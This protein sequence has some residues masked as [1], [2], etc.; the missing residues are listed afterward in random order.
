MREFLPER[1]DKEQNLV[2]IK[3]LRTNKPLAP[4]ARRSDPTAKDAKRD[5]TQSREMQTEDMIAW[6]LHNGWSLA[7]IFPY[8][9]DLGLSGTLRPDQR[10]DMLRLFDDL[11]S[12]KLDGGTIACWQENRPFRDETHIYY[13]QLID[14]MLQHNVVMLVMSPRLY[15]YDMRDPFDMERLRDKFKEAA[16]FIPKHVKGWLHPAR[17]RAAWEYGEWAGLGSLPPGFIVDYDE[18]SPTY[19]KIIPYWPHIEKTKEKFQ[20]FMELGGDIG[21]FYKRLRKS[22]IIYPEFESWVDKRITNRFNLSR[23]PG[24]GYYIRGRSSLVSLLTHPLHYGY[25]PIENVIR[26]DDQGNKIREF[27]PVIDQELLDFAYYRLARTD[28]DGNPIAANSKPRR[29]FQRDSN[30]LYGLLKFRIHSNQGKARTSSHGGRAGVYLIEIM[31]QDDYICDPDIILA[32]PCG[33]IDTIIVNRMMEHVRDISK[34]CESAETFQQQVNEIR[35]KR[36]SRIKQLEASINDINRNQA[37]LTL[38]LGKVELEREEVKQIND[39]E[40]L[41][42][43]QRR[44]ELITEQIDTLE[45]ERRTL[46]QTKADV[47]KQA[48]NDYGSLDEELEELE[49]LWPEYTFEHRRNLINFV[50]KEVFID[51]ISTHWLRIQVLWLHE[52]WGREEMFY[53]RKSGKR[54]EWTDEEIELL[55]ATYASTPYAQLRALF[56]DKSWKAIYDKGRFGLGIMRPTTR[57]GRPAPGEEFVP[58]WEINLSYSD[59]EFMQEQGIN[60]NARCTNWIPVYQ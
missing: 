60:H 22:P 37:G 40:K 18:H 13:N 35:K 42:R 26:R 47:E 7:L 34:K 11:D 6:G 19:K 20:L 53:L 14:K 15:I 12:G 24:G 57:P 41:K 38:S 46:I 39:S 55:R 1:P 48:A 36:Q 52:E 43:L 33:E 5:R 51:S 16:E 25:R 44:K 29:Y 58:R 9:A 30:E 2:L 3:R 4:Y 10:P 32:V 21:L 56:P 28:F 50:I 8:F 54:K 17:E 45:T 23:Y 59:L 27:E 49:K 31:R